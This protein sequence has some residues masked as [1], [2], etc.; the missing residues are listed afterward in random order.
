VAAAAALHNFCLC[1][2]PFPLGKGPLKSPARLF[3]LA[4]FDG[5]CNGAQI[6]NKFLLKIAE[7]DLV[8]VTLFY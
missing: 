1:A 5:F 7:H 6:G 3:C 8:K 4:E 2:A